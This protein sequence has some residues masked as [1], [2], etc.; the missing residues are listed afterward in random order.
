MTHPAGKASKTISMGHKLQLQV[1]TTETLLKKG[2][3][4]IFLQNIS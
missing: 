4:K 2:T 1:C 3:I